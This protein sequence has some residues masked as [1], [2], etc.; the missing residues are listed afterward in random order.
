MVMKRIL[1]GGLIVWALMFWQSEAQAVN[2]GR[3]I[4]C[5][6]INNTPQ[7]VFKTAYGAL[8]TDFGKSKEDIAKLPE[9]DTRYR[10]KGIYGSGYAAVNFAW[11]IYVKQGDVKYYDDETSCAYPLVVEVFLGLQNPKIYVAKE[12]PESSCRFAQILRHQQAHQQINKTALDYFVPVFER[13]VQKTIR[14][15]KAV[16]VK[17]AGAAADGYAMLN[18]YYKAELNPL[19]EGFYQL[20]NR[21][22]KKFDNMI[23]NETEDNLCQEYEVKQEL[24]R[25]NL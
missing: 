13:A 2:I 20:V 7:I 19:F 3:F 17:N 10:E 14:N 23:D 4:S 15:V 1:R 11:N 12:F 8:E 22:H 5:N 18:S 6:S 9:Q 21:E 25:R 16:K 24:I